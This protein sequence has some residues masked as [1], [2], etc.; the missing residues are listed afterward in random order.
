MNAINE[1]ILA[2]TSII[3]ERPKMD[4]YAQRFAQTKNNY[5]VQAEE[6]TF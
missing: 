6:L 1:Q 2:L 5:W 4:G 3:K